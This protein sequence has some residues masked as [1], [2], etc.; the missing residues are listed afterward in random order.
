M[1]CLLLCFTALQ[2]PSVASRLR[3]FLNERMQWQMRT[4]EYLD[5]VLWDKVGMAHRKGSLG[6]LVCSTQGGDRGVPVPGDAMGRYDCHCS[7]Q[8]DSK[9]KMSQVTNNVAHLYIGSILTCLCY[10]SLLHFDLH[11]IF[12]LTMCLLIS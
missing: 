3:L 4:T 1:G 6:Q 11:F 12:I 10:Y 2:I 8:T 7:P 5:P 9:G